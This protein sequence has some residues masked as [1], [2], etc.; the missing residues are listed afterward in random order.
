MKEFELG[1]GVLLAGLAARRQAAA[2]G[3]QEADAG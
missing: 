3:P 1:L 2:E